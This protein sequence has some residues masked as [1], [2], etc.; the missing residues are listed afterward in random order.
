MSCS[1]SG[2]V[3]PMPWVTHRV[4][5]EEH[6]PRAGDGPDAAR[7]SRCW[8]CPDARGGPP[9]PRRPARRGGGRA[10]RRG[11][12]G[13]S[14]AAT[15]CGTDRKML[16]P[17]PPDPGRLPGALL[18]TRPPACA[19]DT[20][21]RVFVGDSVAC[22]TCGAVPARNASADLPRPD[23]GAG[24]LRPAHRGSRRR[25][26]TRSP[27]VWTSLGAAMAEPLAACVHA[28]GARL[29]PTRA[30]VAVLGGGTIGLMLA[31]LLVLDG[32]DVGVVCDRHDE[33]RAQ[34]EAMGALGVRRRSSA[35][36]TT[37]VFEAVG[38]TTAEQGA[39]G[40]RRARAAPWCWSGA[41]RAARTGGS[42]RPGSLH[43]DEVDVRRRLSPH[44]RAEVDRR[45][46]GAGARRRRLAARW[47]GPTS[48]AWSS[49]PAPLGGADLGRARR[50]SS[51]WTRRAEE[52][53]GAQA[54][55][56]VSVPVCC[57]TPELRQLTRSRSA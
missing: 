3:D 50:A 1:R 36:N 26:C 5:L 25:P 54:M 44:A 47:R 48:S 10:G 46:R 17:R 40:P 34:A 28:M 21:E 18:A 57:A 27:T 23:L 39:R 42:S 35:A 31:R 12:R 55:A 30:H 33:R 24:R 13:V 19:L 43:Y 29:T 14:R 20:G 8:C 41:A 52:R 11:A 9:R 32:R 45:A 6:G 51:W 4:G 37:L 22:G 15:A 16:L 2:A 7:R 53:R 49:W 38:R 56:T